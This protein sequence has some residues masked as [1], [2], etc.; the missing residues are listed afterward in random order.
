[1]PTARVPAYSEYSYATST[2][3]VT[4]APAGAGQTFSDSTSCD[5]VTI[6]NPSV[7]DLEYQV[8]A[9]SWVLLKSGSDT[10][11]DIDLSATTLKFR[12]VTTSPASFNIQV[13]VREKPSGVYFGSGDDALH[14]VQSVAYAASLDVNLAEGNYVTVG[15]LTGN[16]A[17]NAPTGIPSKGTRVAYY[18]TQD[19]TGTRTLTW[20]ASHKGAAP[21]S[22]G[23]SDQKQTVWFESDGTSLLYCG[24]T[25][26]Y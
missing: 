14:K 4:S 15:T 20:S 26:W 13:T 8:G 23:T 25:G 12:R 6:S 2:V 16:I 24:A 21:T 9:G 1:M 5:N 7:A 22:A 19:N 3:S 18:F 10:T 17:H 11:F